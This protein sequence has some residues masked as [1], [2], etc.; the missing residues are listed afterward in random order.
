MRNF[1]HVRSSKSSGA[2]IVVVGPRM[3]LARQPDFRALWCVPTQL[4]SELLQQLYARERSA[5]PLTLI[6]AAL[7]LSDD[8]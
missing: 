4:H 5:V 3:M 7:H 8:P 1:L 6:E 2:F